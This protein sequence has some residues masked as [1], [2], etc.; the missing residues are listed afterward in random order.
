MAAHRPRPFVN[1]LER[2]LGALLLCMVVAGCA[3]YPLNT[4]ESA[5]VPA[6]QTVFF[7]RIDVHSGG[8]PI[9]WRSTS[10]GRQ[11]GFG[12][13]EFVVMV[14]EKGSTVPVE[15]VLSGDGTFYWRLPPG[16]YVLAGYSWRSGITRQGRIF[17]EFKVPDDRAAVYIGKLT[18]AFWGPRYQMRVGDEFEEA[19]GRFAAHL[20][21][22]EREVI[23]SLMQ[24][25]E[26]I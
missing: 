1:G 2:W 20:P 11:L 15:Y 18:I 24:L 16:Q 9:T 12:S 8:K 6:G 25:E 26:K 5:Q 14:M 19:K 17:A 4:M 22:W 21:D 3:A 13:G 23:K 7:G 10:F